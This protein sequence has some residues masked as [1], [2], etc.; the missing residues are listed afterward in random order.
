MTDVTCLVGGCEATPTCKGYCNPHYQRLYRHG[1]PLGGARPNGDYVR[2][3]AQNFEAS[4]DRCGPEVPGHPEMGRCWIWG[5]RT[6]IGGYGLFGSKGRKAGRAHRWSWEQANN[7][8]LAPGDEID[9]L[10]HTFD[11]TCLGGLCAHRSC[12]NP[13]HLEPVTHHENALRSVRARTG[14]CRFGHLLS[15]VGFRNG[16]PKRA[17]KTCTADRARRRRQSV[18]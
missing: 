3:S 4:V 12:V 7:R 11:L 1:D 5:G 13:D 14:R 10:C 17:C 18:K 2:A 16:K 8:S 6:D 15:V 9:H